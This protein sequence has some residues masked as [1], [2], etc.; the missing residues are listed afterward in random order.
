M[1]VGHI[2]REDEPVADAAALREPFEER[3]LGARTRDD[4]PRG[5]QVSGQTARLDERALTLG[6]LEAAGGEHDE[7]V[8]GEPE[9][10]AQISAFVTGR[11]LCTGGDLASIRVGGQLNSR[12]Y[13]V[14]PARVDSG[15]HQPRRARCDTQPTTTRVS[16]SGSTVPAGETST[17]LATKWQLRGREKGEATA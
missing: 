14:D 6:C 11:A 1:E 13:D 4:P 16:W 12:R 15:A 10:S 3:A 17:R 5:A 9:A 2:T 8:G 7:G